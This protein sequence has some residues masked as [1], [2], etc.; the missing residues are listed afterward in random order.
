[1][2]S[3][4]HYAM[5]MNSKFLHLVSN[6]TDWSPRLEGTTECGIERAE[7]SGTAADRH[8]LQDKTCK[9]CI[10]AKGWDHG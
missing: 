6:I 5:R 8:N 1:M 4:T 2:K 9:T 3:Q 7:I 10:K